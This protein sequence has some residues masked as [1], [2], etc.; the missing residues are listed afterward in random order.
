M[1]SLKNFSMLHDDSGQNIIVSDPPLEAVK[2][3]IVRLNN[4]E[5]T[6]VQLTVRDLGTLSIYGG[7]AGQ[8]GVSYHGF[9]K[10]DE[11]RWGKAINET[12]TLP[13]EEIDISIGG[14]INPESTRFT[15]PYDT[16]LE[17]AEHFLRH[18]KMPSAVK[19]SGKMDGLIQDA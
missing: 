14:D 11:F 12:A 7:N 8:V 6:I 10:G 15:L 1:S 5:R 4:G 2:T 13:D 19:W 17:I 9:G 16:A 3:N 18:H